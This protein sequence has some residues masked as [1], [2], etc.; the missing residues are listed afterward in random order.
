M[1][2]SKI[3]GTGFNPK[4]LNMG[5]IFNKTASRLFRGR[6]KDSR[7]AEDLYLLLRYPECGVYTPKVQTL[8][9]LWYRL[10]RCI[11]ERKLYLDPYISISQ[12]AKIVGSNRTYISEILAP[13]KG[14]KYF[15]NEYRLKHIA[16]RLEHV[17]IAK[18]TCFLSEEYGF[19]PP[20]KLTDIVLESGFADMRTFRRALSASEGKWAQII[21]GKIY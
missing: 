13:E 4:K 12:V 5:S 8:N 16:Q 19:T 18:E 1:T 10:R 20:E 9:E 7:K 2:T 17:D 3:S 11:E 21:R 15:M 14:Y 6:S